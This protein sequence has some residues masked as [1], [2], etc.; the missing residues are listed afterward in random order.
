MLDEFEVNVDDDSSLEVAEQIVRVRNDC[1]K[2][3]F[4]EVES[5]RQKWQSRKGKNVTFK[6]GEDQDADTDWDTDDD[7]EDDDDDEAALD[8][9][10]EMADAPA[11]RVKE[12][13]EI[14]EDGFTKVARKKR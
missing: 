8:E 2:G 13:P 7:E 9:D 14:D 10:V 4:D 11:R 6:K 3:K 12:A 1:L 5:L